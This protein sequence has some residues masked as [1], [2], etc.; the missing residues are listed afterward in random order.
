MQI[1]Q[2]QEER[3]N[4]TSRIDKYTLSIEKQQNV[5]CCFPNQSSCEQKKTS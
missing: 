1:L 3:N 4:K 5:Q 2:G